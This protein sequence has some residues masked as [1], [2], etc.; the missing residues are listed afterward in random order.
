[1]G[2]T[3]VV[4]RLEVAPR[5]GTSPCA[6]GDGLFAFEPCGHDQPLFPRWTAD[7]AA[8]TPLDPD[9][10]EDADGAFAV[11]V[12]GQVQPV[13]GLVDLADARALHAP[14]IDGLLV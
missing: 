7:G 6:L 12:D 10:P 13:A 9:H 1:V 2:I 11:R 5:Q 14:G 8:P 3:V 4:H